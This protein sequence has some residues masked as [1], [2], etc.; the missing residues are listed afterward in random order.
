MPVVSSYGSSDLERT[1]ITTTLMS[2]AHPPT[3]TGTQNQGGS[4]SVTTHL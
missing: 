3:A 4:M 1:K 2:Q